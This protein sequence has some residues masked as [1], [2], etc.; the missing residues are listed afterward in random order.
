MW[1]TDRLLTKKTKLEL[2]GACLGF[3]TLFLSFL[4][5]T[6]ESHILEV[7]NHSIKDG[8]IRHNNNKY[9]NKVLLIQIN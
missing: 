8:R 1:F 7:I 5:Q 4:H 9:S 3:W 2:K 6:V